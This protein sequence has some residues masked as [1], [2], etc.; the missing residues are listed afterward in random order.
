[1]TSSWMWIITCCICLSFNILVIFLLAYRP[2]G[3][4]EEVGE[5][6]GEAIKDALDKFV[7]PV[8][9]DNNLG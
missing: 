8:Q 2:H 5:Y 6:D 4:L 3:L 7:I 1:M 9:R